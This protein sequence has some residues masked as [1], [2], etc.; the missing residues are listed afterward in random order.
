MPNLLKTFQEC[1]HYEDAKTKVIQGHIR[2]ILCQN[3]S[4]TF[5]FRPIL[6]MICMNANIMKIQYMYMT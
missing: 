3:Y 6:M 1:Q 5:V 4:S 2:P